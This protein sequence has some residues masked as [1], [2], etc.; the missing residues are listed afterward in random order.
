MPHEICIGEKFDLAIRLDNN[1]NNDMSI[2]V[3]SYVFRG[4]KSY[5]GDRDEN[6]KEFVLKGRTSDIVELSNIVDEAE[7][8]DYRLKVVINKDNQK[9]SNEITQDIKINSKIDLKNEEF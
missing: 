7:P 1:D 4:P 6:Q 2:K 5:S 3:W 9:T 8:G